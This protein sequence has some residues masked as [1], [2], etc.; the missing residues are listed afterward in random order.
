MPI[1]VEQIDRW[2]SFPCENQTLE[3]KEAKA[4]YDNEKLFDY[5]V[6]IANEGGGH[7][8]FGVR[9]A[10]PRDVTGTAAINDPV[11]MADKIYRKVSFRVDID[12]VQHPKGRVVVL[13]IPGRPRGTPLHHDGR[14]LMRSGES[15]TSMS[16]DQLRKIIEEGKP[17][18]LE[19]FTDVGEVSA[20]D[21]VALLD[22][23]VYF[24][25]L[26]LPYPSTRNDVIDRLCVERLIKASYQDKYRI[27]KLA[28]ILFAKKLDDFPDIKRKA[29]RLIVFEGKDKFSVKLDQVGGRG[30]AAAYKGLVSYVMAQLPQNE[31]IEDTLRKRVSLVPEIVMRELVANA[32][33]HQDF[34]VSGASVTVEVYTDRVVISNPGQPVVNLERFIDSYRSR[35]ER[36]ADLMRR[37]KVCEEQ[38]LGIDRVIQSIEFFQLP[39]P[40]FRADDLRT[41]VTIFGPKTFQSMTRDDRVRACYQHCVLRYVMNEKMTN[42]SL[43][44]RFK[45]KEAQG[46]TASQIISQTLEAQLIKT[47]PSVGDSKKYARYVP[48]WG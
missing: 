23:Q 6:A 41:I 2:C 48:F 20:A 29:P 14:Y 37:M 46:A 3:F 26:S 10:T 7:L 39:A 25:R 31:V 34:T 8:V 28:A 24:E 21:V 17:D 40:E 42:E 43:R 35:N 27:K 22:T 5:C 47:D 30:Y 19:E 36:L 9:N 16:P 12:I 18:W 38:G 13:T 44:Q 4:Q 1:T 33:I 45:L 15:L 32:L 11:G